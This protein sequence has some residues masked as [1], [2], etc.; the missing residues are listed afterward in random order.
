MGVFPLESGLAYTK[1]MLHGVAMTK[2][3]SLRESDRFVWA[4]S[5]SVH[6]DQYA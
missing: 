3:L 6:K 5:V 2:V 4:L 1:T